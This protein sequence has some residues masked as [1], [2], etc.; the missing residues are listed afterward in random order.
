MKSYRVAAW[1]LVLVL[2]AL[3]AWIDTAAKKQKTKTTEPDSVVVQHILISFKGKVD[4]KKGVTRTKKEAEA[5]ATELFVRAKTE[6]FDALVK[7]YTDDAYPG[8]YKMTNEG[9]PIMT[10]A[11]PRSG[12]VPSFGEV[13]FG[14]EVGEIGMTTYSSGGSPYGWHIIK[15]LS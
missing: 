4:K 12:M 15:R 3:P 14:L 1:A 8:I 13:A 10:G 9:A 11:V 2:V 5:L 6:D 7:E